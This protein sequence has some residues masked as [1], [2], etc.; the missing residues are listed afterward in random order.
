MSSEASGARLLG[1]DR[2][3]GFSQPRSLPEFEPPTVPFGSM[4]PDLADYRS[5]QFVPHSVAASWI[6]SGLEIKTVAGH[7]LGQLAALCVSGVLSLR[8]ALKMIYGR[9]SLIQNKWGSERGRMLSV[10]AY[11]PTVEAFA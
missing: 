4:Q 3:P 2:S 1:L 5:S 11:I 9:A 8:D 10:E 7:S 6:R